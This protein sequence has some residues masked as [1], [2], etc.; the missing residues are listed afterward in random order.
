[1]VLPPKQ[2]VDWL[3]QCLAHNIPAGHFKGADN[4]HL[5]QVWM[6]A[7]TAAVKYPP[8]S[9]RLKWVST[10]DV[11]LAHVLNQSRYCVRVKRHGIGFAK[12]GYAVICGNFQEYPVASTVMGWWVTHHVCLELCYLHIHC[13]P[14]L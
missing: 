2:I 11:P 1:V 4:P 12:A 9:F 5:G 13:P 10:D 8:E 3:V 7:E 14:C 6:L